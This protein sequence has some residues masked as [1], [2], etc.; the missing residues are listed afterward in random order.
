MNG[1]ILFLGSGSKEGIPNL[2]HVFK[3]I[4]NINKGNDP[5]CEI[6]Q[7]SIKIK[8]KNV[9]NPFSIII[10]S[11]LSNIDNFQNEDHNTFLFE[12]GSSFRTSMLQYAIP[13]NI[14]RIDSIFCMSSNESSFNGIDETREVQ[15]YERPVSN[16]GIVFYEPKIRVPTY[17]TC[18][19][20]YALND[21]Y[22]YIINYSLK[23]DLKSKTKIGCVRLNIL[24]PRNSPNAISIDSLS[25][26]NDYLN[27]S[28]NF[29]ITDST[30]NNLTFNPI[31]IQYS[32]EIKII[33]L[34]FIDSDNKLCSG[35]CIEYIHDKKVICIVPTYSIIPKETLVL[36]KA[37][38]LINI[39]IFPI[40][41]NDSFSINSESIKDSINF[42]AKM[43]NAE[44]VFFYN[45][46]CN[47]SH[48][49]VQRIVNEKSIEFPNI[50][51]TVSFDSQLVPI[52]S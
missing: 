4:D 14:N 35:Y 7:K 5:F 13:A 33:S 10:K 17:L 9:R 21:W 49:F 43:M 31:I 44:K 18:S 24:D 6:C 12:I 42:C 39:L 50:N 40:I 20:I 15:I 37:I 45:I 36:L 46:N 11:P 23:D 38:S 1:Y 34:F 41:P 28:K 16:D 48:E 22:R 47:C 2:E 27:L 26:F 32:N 3:N 19:A 29:E 25:A 8:S 51:F 30:E 52:N